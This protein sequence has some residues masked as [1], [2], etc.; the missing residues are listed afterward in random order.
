MK[1]EL[2][3]KIHVS[4][5]SSLVLYLLKKIKETKKKKEIFV[6]KHMDAKE[7]RKKKNCLYN[8]SL[9][10]RI[11]LF[12]TKLPNFGCGFLDG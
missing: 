2:I 7:T 6:V 9:E 10:N 8:P 5:H 3:R 12:D 1:R 4:N 11:R